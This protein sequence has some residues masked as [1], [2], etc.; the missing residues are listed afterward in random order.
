[1]ILEILGGFGYLF[2]LG[3]MYTRLQD[4]ADEVQVVGAAFWPIV[5]PALLGAH[6]FRWLTG[7]HP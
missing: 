4:K 5:A 2:G 3:A 6:V 1:M 7:R